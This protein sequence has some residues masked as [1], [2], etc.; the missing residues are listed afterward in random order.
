MS[1]QQVEELKLREQ[2]DGSYIIG[3]EPKDTEKTSDPAPEDEDAEDD[4]LVNKNESPA[5]DEGAVDG[6]TAEEAEA[7][8]QRNRERR[9]ENKSRRKEYVESLK[10]ELS[11]RDAI[12]SDLSS[13]VESVERTSTGAQMAQLDGAIQ[14]VEQ[15]LEELRDINKQAIEQ[16]NG[17]VAVAAQ[18]RMFALRTRYAQLAEIKKGMTRQTSQPQAIDPRLKNH[19]EAWAVKNK[20]FD[21]SGGDTDSKIAL[22]IDR[23]MASEGWNPVTSEYWAELDSRLKKYLPHRVSTSYNSPKGNK[24][25]S[26][27]SGGGRESSNTSSSSYTLSQE[28][29]SALKD[30]GLWDDPKKRAEAIKRFQQYDKENA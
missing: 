8:R 5:E 17:D 29:V 26:P 30:A 21:A 22:T 14:S 13:R 12:I 2:K 19:A 10:R 18:E 1:E 27:V 9:A 16:A 11:A 28:R 20:W 23:Q 15:Q 24:S 3:E 4:T 7:R 6:E 25:H